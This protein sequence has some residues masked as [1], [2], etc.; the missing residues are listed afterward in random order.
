M[1]AE[2]TEAVFLEHGRRRREQ[3]VVT[4]AKRFEST[5]EQTQG[6]PVKPQHPHGRT[7]HLADEHHVAAAGLARNAAEPAELPEPKVD[8]AIEKAYG[9]S[10]AAKAQEPAR[11][12]PR[13][14]QAEAAPEPEPR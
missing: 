8:P 7:Q 11:L 10:P 9:D 1:R 14:P 4:A 6:L 3:T 13:R 5:R 12:P 2:N